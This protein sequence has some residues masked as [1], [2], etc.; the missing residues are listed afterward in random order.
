MRQ[1]RGAGGHPKKVTSAANP[2]VKDIR[3]LAQKK[4]R[5]RTGLFVA[6]GLQLVRYG[7]DSAWPMET[8]VYSGAAKEESAVLNAAARGKAAGA[9]L[10]EVSAAVLSRLSRRD[11]P[12][13]V[14]GVFRQTWTPLASV[15]RSG[16]WVALEAVRDPGNL[17]TI[18]RTVD[19]AGGA[20][21]VL[22]GA[23]CDPFSPETVR[24]TMGSVFHVPVAAATAD[25]LAAQAKGAGTP[26]IGTH[27]AALEDFRKTA[28]P[29]PCVI[30]MGNEQKGLSEQLA[31]ACDRLVSIPMAGRA[32]SLN[33]AVAT[34]LMIYEARRGRL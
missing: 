2:L 25:G 34:G 24:A 19:A 31:S 30:L 33:L 11:N 21:V 18:I 27:L 4:F 8:F 9:R 12:Q 20:G 26:M 23:C 6:E 17:G 5:D 32:E 16:L 3:A 28:Y 7:L 1:S 15:G 13:S 10:V 29:D 22:V 14:L